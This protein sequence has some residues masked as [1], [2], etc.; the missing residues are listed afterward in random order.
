MLV[1]VLDADVLFPMVL[2]DTLLRAAA[3]GCFR[4]HWTARILDEVARNLVGHHGMDQ[5]QVTTL[6]TLMEE[7]F[8]DAAVE[9]WEA[10]EGQMKNHPKDR[11][12]AAAAAV[13]GAGIIVTSNVRDFVELPDGVVA[14]T[15]DQFLAELLTANPGGLAAALTSQAAGYRRPATTVAELIGQLGKTAPTFASKALDGLPQGRPK[16]A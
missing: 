2:R 1:A 10:L 13:I 16:P 5:A 4:L 9:G 7:A 3:S 12:V 14:M 15:P 6:R 11:H 8:P